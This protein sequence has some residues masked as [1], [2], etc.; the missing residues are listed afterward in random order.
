MSETGFFIFNKA[1][2]A[3]ME[4]LYAAALALFLRPFFTRNLRG[5]LL[6][7]F[8]LYLCTTLVYN[9]LGRPQGFFSLLLMVLLTAFSGFL[10]ASLQPSFIGTPKQLA[11]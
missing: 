7:V 3:G 5:R 9:G 2:V 4:L 11:R 10:K 8:G 1:F 6:G